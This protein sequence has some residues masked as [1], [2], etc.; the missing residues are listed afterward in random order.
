MT[1]KSD[2]STSAS[3]GQSKS[4]PDAKHQTPVQAP[5]G[6]SLTA[7]VPEPNPKPPVQVQLAKD[8]NEARG[9]GRHTFGGA[10]KGCRGALQVTR[11]KASGN[12]TAPSPQKSGRDS[13]GEAAWNT[14]TFGA[15]ASR[16]LKEKMSKQ[17]R[18]A[19]Q[20]RRRGA[21]GS[22]AASTRMDL[23]S[24]SMPRGR[25]AGGSCPPERRK[26]PFV[27]GLDVERVYAMRRRH[28]DLD[29]KH[30]YEVDSVGSRCS[31]SPPSSLDG[32]PDEVLS[33]MPFNFITEA[34]LDEAVEKLLGPPPARPEPPQAHSPREPG[35]WMKWT[36][37]LFNPT[38]ECS[39]PKVSSV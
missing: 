1:S 17:Q 16:M 13:D 9:N 39:G 18:D 23:L 12:G 34:S 32:E 24:P 10:S 11:Y 37:R 2:A 35:E 28:G 26:G 6:F 3:E 19:R 30:N 7:P 38:L 36:A 14:E 29:L 5:A 4:P 15:Q 22:P 25:G 8:A 21:S 27:P 33:S 20:P 31:S